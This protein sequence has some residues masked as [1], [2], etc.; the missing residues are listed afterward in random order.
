MGEVKKSEANTDL[1]MA[2]VESRIKDAEKLVDEPADADVRVAEMLERLNLTSEEADAV[3]LEPRLGSNWQGT[4]P[5]YSSHS[6]NH[7]SYETGM[8]EPERSGCK[9]CCR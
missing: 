6:D 3:I 1:V 9:I 7:V 2:V 5:K 4:Y 8:G